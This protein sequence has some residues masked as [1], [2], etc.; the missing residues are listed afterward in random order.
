MKKIVSLLAISAVVL[1]G[2]S[3]SGNESKGKTLDV[4]LPLKTTSIAP[5][6]DRRACE[7]RCCGSFI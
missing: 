5:Y 6:G 4:E 1:A 7:N 2:C 3:G